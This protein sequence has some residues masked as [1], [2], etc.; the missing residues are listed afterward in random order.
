MSRISLL[1]LLMVAALPAQAQPACDAERPAQTGSADLYFD[2]EQPV[3]L[4][5]ERQ[6]W[7]EPGQS[8]LTGSVRAEQGDTRLD[9]DQLSYQ[10]DGQWQATGNVRIENPMAKLSG[11]R[12]QGK[13]QPR[14]LEIHQLRYEFFAP[15]R[16]GAAEYL[17]LQEQSVKLQQASYTSCS[18]AEPDWLMEADDIRLNRDK[19][20]GEADNMV[21]RIQDVPVFY[22]PYLSFPID[23]RRR[24]GV[25]FPSFGYSTE[26][27]LDYAQPYYLNLAPEYDALLT[28]RYIQNRGVQ[29]QTEFRYLL[30]RGSGQLNLEFLPNDRRVERDAEQDRSLLDWQQELQFG[31]Y[32][33][34]QIRYSEVSD[35][36]Y[37]HD[38]GSGS[39]LLADAPLQRLAS[40]TYERE[41]WSTNT[42]IRDY[43]VLDSPVTPYQIL[44]RVGIEGDFIQAWRSLN[45]SYGF[46]HELVRF[47]HPTATNAERLDLTAY[48]GLPL[49]YAAGYIHP[50]LQWQY[51]GYNQSDPERGLN[52][53]QS[54]QMTDLDRARHRSIPLFQLDTGLWLDRTLKLWDQTYLQTLEPQLNY[55][56]VPYRNQ[57][58]IGLYDTTEIASGFERL[59]RDNRFIGRDRIGDDNRLTLVLA[60]R[61]LRE[62]DGTERLRARLG[63]S[64]YFADRRVQLEPNTPIEQRSQSPLISELGLRLSDD[65]WLDTEWQYDDKYSRTSQFGN[66]FSYQPNPGES[67]VFGYR[68]RWL[69]Q[70]DDIEQRH[71]GARYPLNERWGLSGFWQQ[72]VQTKHSTDLMW[73][74]EYQSCCWTVR[75]LW[76]RHLETRPDDLANNQT[77]PDYKSGVYVQFELKGLSTVGNSQ[78]TSL[79]RDRL[80]PD[81]Y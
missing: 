59:L 27:G 20:W 24:S 41:F 19:G 21:L 38:L 17:K 49:D 75:T 22:L 60:T 44:P 2:P 71:I 4:S 13:T 23:S 26:D 68:Y 65:G 6:E 40:L 35:N 28:P 52:N 50:K 57:D 10:P 30:S 62:D 25:L 80:Q 33:H 11:N 47:R 42:A 15:Y 5:A 9:A 32:W 29:L 74:A 45:L 70:Q 53:Q 81:S 1:S 34:S 31:R 77:N 12:L 55:L 7:S 14:E 43:Q 72:D 51:T 58:D 61:V 39:N 3:R 8:E 67:Y 54:Q 66:Q 37:L 76:R 64:L 36:N 63:R 18:G 46:D 48:F 56:Y 73:G 78:L 16:Q 69:E 79:L